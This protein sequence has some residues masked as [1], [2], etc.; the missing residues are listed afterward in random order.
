MK[1]MRVI[2]IL[3]GMSC[4]STALYYRRLN[5]EARRILGG[6]HSADTIIRSVDFATIEKMQKQNQWSAAG[7]VLADAAAGLERGGAEVLILATN[8][9]HKVAPRIKRAVDIPFIHIADATAEAIHKAG[10]SR[11]GLMATA[12]TMEQTFYIGR[13][14]DS[15]LNVVVPNAEDRATVHEIIFEELCMGLTFPSS[16]SSFEEV[17]GSVMTRA[18]T[19]TLPTNQNRNSRQAYEQRS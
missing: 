15:G 14:E 8:T 19:R 10:F 4:E 6:L 17:A 5:A 2:G 12:Y 11:P 16:K 9:M 18:L 7:D 3:G 13:L 1:S